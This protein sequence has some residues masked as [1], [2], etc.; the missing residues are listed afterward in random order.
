MVAASSRL[1][2][3]LGIVVFC[4]TVGGSIG[5]V[6]TGHIFDITDSYRMAFIILLILAVVGLT[7]AVLLK[8]LGKGKTID[9]GN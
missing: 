1:A 3:L 4:G 9:K 7:S 5:M 2:T 8:P 6:L